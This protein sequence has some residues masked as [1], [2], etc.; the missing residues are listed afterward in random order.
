MNFLNKI[1]NAIADGLKSPLANLSNILAPGLDI[2]DLL[3]GTASALD[4]FSGFLDCGQTNKDKWPPIRKYEVSGGPMEKGAD[5]FAYVSYAMNKQSTG[6]GTKG[7][8]GNITGAIDGISGAIGGITDTVQGITGALQN[9]GGLVGG[10][11]KS[12]FGNL[13]PSGIT[14]S[15]GSVGRIS[16]LIE[17]LSAGGSCTGGKQNCGNPTMQI[18]GGG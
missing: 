15:L 11:V 17:D 6:G 7:T 8:I 10:L 18:F 14:N 9:P 2:A 3:R 5:P 12:K 16:G 13:I 1:T 4:D